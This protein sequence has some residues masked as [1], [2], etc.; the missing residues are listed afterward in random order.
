MDALRTVYRYW[1]AL[2]LLAVVVQIGAAGYGAF[3]AADKADPGP[4]SDDSFTSGFDFHNGFGYIIFLASIVLLLLGL[5][6]RLGRPR[7][8]WV[9]AVPV[10]VIIQILLANAG[11]SAPIVGVLHPINAFLILG[12]IGELAH[13]AWRLERGGAP[14][15]PAAPAQM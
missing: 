12:V 14:T 1:L 7:I 15:V 2:L 8:W 9:L 11:E 6:A 5:G 3:N 4:L 10:L 13:R